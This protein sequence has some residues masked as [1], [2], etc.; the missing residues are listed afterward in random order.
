MDVSTHPAEQVAR[1][2]AFPMTA[3][4]ARYAKERELPDAVAREHERELKRYLALCA[5]HPSK[6]YG[7]K[8]PVD[9]LWHTFLVFTHEYAGF[10]ETVAG[11]FLH[12][13]PAEPDTRDVSRGRYQLMLQDY[14]AT[15]E[16]APPVHV[17]PRETA[18]SCTGNCSSGGGDSCGCSAA[19]S[20]S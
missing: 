6:E 2:M 11:R 17:W 5:L 7:M 12:H 13:V 14:E 16:E 9:D 19:C 1:A 3:V 4:V 8:G 15:Y 10:C 20:Q 18:S